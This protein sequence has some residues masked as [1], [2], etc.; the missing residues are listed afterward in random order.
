MKTEK[1]EQEAEKRKIRIDTECYVFKLGVLEKLGEHYQAELVVSS[2][3]NY[4]LECQC[5]ST[6]FG[7]LDQITL[8]DGYIKCSNIEACTFQIKG[9]FLVGQPPRIYKIYVDDNKKK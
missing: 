6:S 5:G 3:G 1:L 8:K 4:I 2:R 7:T 9:G